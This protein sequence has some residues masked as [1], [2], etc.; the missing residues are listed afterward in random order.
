MHGIFYTLTVLL[1]NV[2]HFSSSIPF[3]AALPRNKSIDVPGG[4]RPWYCCHFND[5]PN[6]AVSRLGGTTLTSPANARKKNKYGIIPNK[7]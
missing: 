6:K 5:C 7:I 1:R 4:R 2:G 3:C